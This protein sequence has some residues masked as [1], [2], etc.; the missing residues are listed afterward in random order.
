M[1]RGRGLAAFLDDGQEGLEV[2]QSVYL[3]PTFRKNVSHPASID[4]PTCDAHL[5]ACFRGQCRVWRQ[6]LQPLAG[7]DCGKRRLLDE[8]KSPR[9]ADAFDGRAEWRVLA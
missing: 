9:I 5:A 7:L 2:V 3:Y 6:Q 1:A 4:A 8:R